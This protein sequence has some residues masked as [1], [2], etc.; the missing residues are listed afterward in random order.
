MSKQE[1]LKRVLKESPKF[2]FPLSILAVSLLNV[3]FL[4]SDKGF[5]IID[6]GSFDKLSDP[7]Q[8]VARKLLSLGIKIGFE[9]IHIRLDNP[10]EVAGKHKKTGRPK[11]KRITTPDFNFTF[12]GVTCYLEIGSGRATS[13]KRRQF[14][15]M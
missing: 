15:V 7:E 9:L 3:S 4:K 10:V 11:T 5:D 8:R 12:N 1:V 13:H 14:K 6:E 2:L